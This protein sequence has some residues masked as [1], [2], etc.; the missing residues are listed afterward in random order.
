[1]S[2]IPIET[3]AGGEGGFTNVKA[4][5]ALFRAKLNPLDR[6]V[7]RETGTSVF[8]RPGWYTHVFISP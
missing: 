2:T 1:P 4:G 3:D 6:F 7:T 5:L 8:V